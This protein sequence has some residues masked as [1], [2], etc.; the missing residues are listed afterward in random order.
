MKCKATVFYGY[1]KKATKNLTNRPIGIFHYLLK[2]TE[3]NV[4]EFKKLVGKYYVID[5]IVEH[6]G[7]NIKFSCRLE[8]EPDYHGE[9]Y[10]NIKYE[11]R[12]ETCGN[13]IHEGLPYYSGIDS[14]VELVNRLIKEE[15]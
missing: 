1:S 2:S 6:C 12:C 15:E 10:L 4:E 13:V 9:S 3:F 5:T 7:G 11:F 8:E 14:L